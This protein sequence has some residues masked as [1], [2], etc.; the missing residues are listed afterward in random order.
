MFRDLI[1]TTKEEKQ[2]FYDK[3]PEWKRVG[4]TLLMESDE[5]YKSQGISNLSDL[6]QYAA[7]VYNATYP[8]DAGVTDLKNRKNS[9]N[10]FIAYHIINKK[11]SPSMFINAYDTDHMVKLIGG[12]MYEYLEPMCPNTLIEIKKE[13]ALGGINLINYNSETGK[14]IKTIVNLSDSSQMYNGFCYGTR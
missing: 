4:Y 13:R 5:V 7:T 8:E 10:R 9:L 3:L 2:W 11:L 6:K 14:S 1:V 12:D